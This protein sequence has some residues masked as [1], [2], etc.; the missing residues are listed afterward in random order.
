MRQLAFPAYDRLHYMRWLLR[1]RPSP[2]PH[3]L[4]ERTIKSYAR[5]FGLPSLVETGTYLGDTVHAMRGVFRRIYS[6]EIDE[7]LAKAAAE[8]FVHDAH[9]TIIRGDSGTELPALL[10][11]LS[12]PC[13]FW[14]DGHYSGGITSGAEGGSPII[15]EL[16]A[17]LDHATRASDVILVDDAR[18]FVGAG[19]YPQLSEVEELVRS[20]KRQ[21]D[22]MVEDDIIRITPRRTGSER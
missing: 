13:L 4:K 2:P 5:R 20:Q 7:A 11:R 21:L 9:V 15:K 19:G 8:R 10:P 22:Y 3:L 1:S 14:L 16:T 12:G 17:I 6:I 18:L